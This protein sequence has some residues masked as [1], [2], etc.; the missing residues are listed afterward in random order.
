MQ[1]DTDMEIVLRIEALLN[2]QKANRPDSP[3]W[4]DASEQLKPLYAEMASRYPNGAPLPVDVLAVCER[5]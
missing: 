2:V 5:F 1:I 3:L 4:I